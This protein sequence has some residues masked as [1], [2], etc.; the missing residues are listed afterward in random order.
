MK[1]IFITMTLMIAIISIGNSAVLRTMIGF[2]QRE[3]GVTIIGYFQASI[4]VLLRTPKAW[5]NMGQSDPS[6]NTMSSI[7]L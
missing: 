5:M 1:V 2:F 3:T 7:T 6:I 4:Q